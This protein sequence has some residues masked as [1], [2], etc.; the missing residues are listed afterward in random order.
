MSFV[1]TCNES[2]MGFSVIFKNVKGPYTPSNLRTA[3]WQMFCSLLN[4]NATYVSLKLLVCVPLFLAGHVNSLRTA[5][6]FCLCPQ[7]LAH[8]KVVDKCL[9]NIEWTRQGMLGCLIIHKNQIFIHK[10]QICCPRVAWNVVRLWP[11]TLSS[12]KRLVCPLGICVFWV[13]YLISNLRH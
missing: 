8:G 10:N 12:K 6:Y 4:Y 1:L 5:S 9:V 2:L 11:V 13:S 7:Q 3:V